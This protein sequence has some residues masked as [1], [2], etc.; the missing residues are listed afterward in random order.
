MYKVCKFPN[1][2]K[3]QIQVIRIK[4]NSKMNYLAYAPLADCAYTFQKKQIEDLENSLKNNCPEALSFLSKKYLLN[5]LNKK[6]KFITYPISDPN[7]YT[8]L[9][10]LPNFKC[11]YKC[12]YCYSAL[13]RSNTEISTHALKIMLD[14]FV[15]KTRIN[16]NQLSIFI[17]GGGEPLLSWKNLKGEL[18]AA[19]KKANEQQIKL[20][21]LMMTNGSLLKR[22]ITSEL[23]SMNINICVSYDILKDV[24]NRQRAQNDQVL[25]NIKAAQTIVDNLSIS[26]TITPLNVER[27]L[28]MVDVLL[29]ELPHIKDISFDPV[30]N[31]TMFEDTYGLEKFY[32]TFID[33]YLKAAQYA[34]QNGIRLS[35]EVT[36]KFY[37]LF[38]RYCAGKLCLT[39]D[40]KIT[41]CHSISSKNEKGFEDVVY[42]HIDQD[43]VF[44]DKK[45]YLNAVK[46]KDR[47]RS[48]DCNACIARWHCG[49][50]CLM[51]R[52]NYNKDE[53]QIYCQ[54]M[55]KF[56][57]ILI[58]YKLIK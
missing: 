16:G 28:E 15:D 38:D 32:D 17:S 54:Y 29:E 35:C 31:I 18:R 47:I 5:L 14:Y 41:I 37:G 19:I 48:N 21:I 4:N 55:R 50:G 36:R 13:G 3:K 30:V 39:P 9:S 52:N 56:I 1:L 43:N 33:N 45:K 44:L 25:T 12:S 8:K 20:D 24:Q 7:K 2:N 40:A 51:Y 42:G 22:K 57:T 53:F 49:G 23:N 58:M 26:S 11:N 6:N 34:I 46:Y 27:Q 10:I